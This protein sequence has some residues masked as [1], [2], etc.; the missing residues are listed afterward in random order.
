M[1]ACQSGSSHE[2][3]RRL[4]W[5]LAPVACRHDGGWVPRQALPRSAP[6]R[7]PR[8][9]SRRRTVFDRYNATNERDREQALAVTGNVVGGQFTDTDARDCSKGQQN[10]RA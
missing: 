2:Q 10:R 5:V 4:G 6:D 9:G 8:H 7:D 3:C 1:A